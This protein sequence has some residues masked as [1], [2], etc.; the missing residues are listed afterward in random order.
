MKI[1]IESLL[2]PWYNHNRWL[3]VQKPSSFSSCVLVF[4]L[5]SFSSFSSWVLCFLLRSFSSCVLF[6]L[7]RSFPLASCVFPL[8]FL[9]LL[10]SFSSC[11]LFFLLKAENGW[12]NAGVVTSNW[13]SRLK[14]GHWPAR[15]FIGFPHVYFTAVD[16][17]YWASITHSSR[18]KNRQ[19][20]GSHAHAGHVRACVA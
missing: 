18:E 11:D 12:I 8:A 7:L 9:F 17:G 13:A 20:R 16:P 5:R 14:L 10:R 19:T 15:A 1:I 4:L 2:P 3:G 6:F